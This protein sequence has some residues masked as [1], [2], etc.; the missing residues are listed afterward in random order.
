MST[1]K[2]YDNDINVSG[3]AYV[4]PS[5]ITY[6]IKKFIVNGLGYIYRYMCTGIPVSGAGY[7]Q[8]KF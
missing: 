8:L 6:S 1:F 3:M 5:Q 4:L 7:T 2:L